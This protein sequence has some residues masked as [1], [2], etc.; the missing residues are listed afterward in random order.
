M[1]SKSTKFFRNSSLIKRAYEYQHHA[2]ERAG[3]LG[4]CGFIRKLC[5]FFIVTLVKVKSFK[6]TKTFFFSVRQLEKTVSFF[7]TKMRTKVSAWERQQFVVFS[8][9]TNNDLVVT[10]LVTVMMC[11][12]ALSEHIH[13]NHHSTVIFDNMNGKEQIC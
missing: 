6:H 5:S 12:L 1:D 13:P 8:R 3:S 7:K 11:S 2:V 9:G 4:L 10:K